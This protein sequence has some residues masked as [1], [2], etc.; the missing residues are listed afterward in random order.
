MGTAFIGPS[1]GAA[2]DALRDDIA[3]A[4]A[5]VVQVH[6]GERAQVG[7]LRLD[8]LWPP[9]PLGDIQ[10][11]NPASITILVTGRL[12]SLFTGDLN[13]ASQDALLA[14]GP[15]P[16]VDVIKVSHHGSADQ[17][18]AFYAAT[19]AAVGLMGVGAHN[20]YHHP[21]ARLLSI[22][23]DD[24]IQPFRTDQDGLL[25]VARRPDGLVVWSERPVTA[26]VWTPAR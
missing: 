19:G 21:T 20:E 23:R 15:L 12:R 26:A 2:A 9:D 16:H 4:G 11:G 3:A 24:R 8:V 1:Q 6:R 25:L 5:H 13:E 22:L 10:P 18:P 17:S 7:R 14:L